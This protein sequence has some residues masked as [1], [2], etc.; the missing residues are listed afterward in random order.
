MVGCRNLRLV[1]ALCSCGRGNGEGSALSDGIF[2]SRRYFL[3][4]PLYVGGSVEWV[5][6]LGD[7]YGK[8]VVRLR[9]GFCITKPRDYWSGLDEGRGF[10]SSLLL[11]R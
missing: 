9:L 8:L 11:A 2:W 6:G 5:V 10:L 4:A 1:L 3:G 7:V